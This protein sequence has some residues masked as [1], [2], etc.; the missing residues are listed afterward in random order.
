MSG[1]TLDTSGY[2]HGPEE[3][4]PAAGRWWSDLTPFEQGYVRELLREIEL[5]A[6]WLD[7]VDPY[8]AP[9]FS[10]LAPETFVAMRADCAAVAGAFRDRANAGEQLWL[11]RQAGRHP[12][13]GRLTLTLDG[14]GKVRAT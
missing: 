3:N 7:T 2:V 1:F 9:G 14:D 11:D 12:T 10:D 6:K 13:L 8:R 5:A 4:G